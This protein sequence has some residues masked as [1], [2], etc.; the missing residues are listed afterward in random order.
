MGIYRKCVE[1]DQCLLSLSF[2]S[3][4]EY[5]HSLKASLSLSL[6]P[7]VCLSLSVCVCVCVCVFVCT[8][9]DEYLHNHL[10]G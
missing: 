10:R 6:S 3:V 5:L 8:S 4:D 9:A 1:E 2:T 7:S